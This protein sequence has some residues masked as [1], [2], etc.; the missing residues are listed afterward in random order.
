MKLW[1][2]GSLGKLKEEIRNLVKGLAE[3]AAR[4]IDVFM[5]GYTHLQR[6]Q[7]VRWSH[8]LLR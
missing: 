2:R 7:P 5:P 1:L 6:A 4:E 8:W 3:R